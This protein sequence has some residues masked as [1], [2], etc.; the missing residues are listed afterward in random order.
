MSYATC[1]FIVIPIVVV[2]KCIYILHSYHM[3]P[4]ALRPFNHVLQSCIDRR[5]V[6][7]VKNDYAGDL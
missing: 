1:V 2:I 3:H 7:K 4:F 5:H 6:V